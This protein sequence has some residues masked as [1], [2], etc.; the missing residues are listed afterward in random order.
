LLLRRLQLAAVLA[1]GALAAGW[2]GYETGLLFERLRTW[3]I[4]R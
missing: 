4:D 2:I 1:A 3:K